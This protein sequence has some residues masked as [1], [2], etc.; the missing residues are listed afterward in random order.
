MDP[1]T[2]TSIAEAVSVVRHAATL[3][4]FRDLGRTAEQARDRPPCRGLANEVL[5]FGGALFS[6]QLLAAE[7]ESTSTE[8][9][10]VG[11]LVLL[12]RIEALF[13]C[14][15]ENL[16]RLTSRLVSDFK[17]ESKVL[18]SRITHALA[19]S[20]SVTDLVILLAAH[21]AGSTSGSDPQHVKDWVKMLIDPRHNRQPQSFYL[22]KRFIEGR[23]AEFPDYSHAA[24]RWIGY[25]EEHWA[26][27]EPELTQ[28]FTMPP[29]S[30]SFVQWALEYARETLPAR[31]GLGCA[32]PAPTIDLS[33]NLCN[34]SISPLHLAA[35]LG[36]PSLVQVL[37]HSGAG[38]GQPSPLGPPLYCAFVGHRVLVVGDS[39]ESW[40]AILRRG[41][42][43]AH[44]HAAVRRLL[45]FRPDCSW[46]FQWPGTHSVSL[47]GLAFWFACLVNDYAIFE[48][49]VEGGAV[50]DNDFAFLISNIDLDA[51]AMPQ[52]HTLA[53][54]L[55]CAF[56]SLYER[57]EQWPWHRAD[58]VFRAIDDLMTQRELEFGRYLGQGKRLAKVSD[59]RLP[60]LIRG[61]ILE[62][63]VCHLK[64]LSID[65]RF[66]PNLLANEDEEEEGTIAHLAVEGNSI[67]IVDVLIAA[68]SDFAAKDGNNRTPLM[69]VEGVPMLSRL[70]HLGIST[71]EIDVTG[72]NIWHLAAA[73]NDVPLLIWLAA[74]D[75]S[76]E[77][78]LA[79]ITEEGYTPLEEA[80]QYN[81]S[82]RVHKTLSTS[83]VEA[84]PAHPVAALSILD[85][86]AV[87]QQ[88]APF[89]LISSAVEWGSLTL[90]Q[91]LCAAGVDP[92]ALDELGRT[93]LHHLNISATPA[94]VTLVQG[95]CDGL[96]LNTADADEEH[97]AA[98]SVIGTGLTPAETILV[99][100]SL[101]QTPDHSWTPSQHNSCRGTLSREAYMLLLTPQVLHHRDCFGRG[102]WA[103]FCQNV[104]LQLAKRIGTKSIKSL[105]HPYDPSL[106]F[107]RTSLFTAIECLIQQGALD[108]H[109]KET[110]LPA[111]LCLR[112]TENGEMD[113]WPEPLLCFAQHVVERFESPLATKF[114]QSPE[115]TKL[116]VAA[117]R[118]DLKKLTQMLNQKLIVGS[119][120]AA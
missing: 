51:Y 61:A 89:P 54:V 102:M 68:G 40:S 120:D 39:P 115:A 82:L 119:A 43:L 75:R 84:L 57:T 117:H 30:F 37:L 65:P 42:R 28:L 58:S 33:N 29:Q 36:L 27:L 55:T 52:K 103:R 5:L 78:N 91:R 81:R 56:D 45:E 13:Q 92:R 35:A 100:T 80:L 41:Q 7:L 21:N 104:I 110:G 74:N 70:M 108:R 6:L 118:C 18:R 22:E 53:M 1:V 59:Q 96:P 69:R 95:L 98:R 25:A 99:N 106:A 34:G 48:K 101:V 38:S 79:A 64:R 114:Y 97:T 63:E 31:F 47:A 32:D 12:R 88:P 76:K 19:R 50:I 94:L 66:D 109:E 113:T 107:L 9:V 46:R 8:P 17:E 24:T 2:P 49:V 23:Q 77:E 71:T 3:L 93:A 112:I 116:F 44:R 67:D 11:C 73:T 20:R 4:C 72:R 83:G 105:R 111:I 15:K 90:V 14:I 60:E 85:A 86:G 16:G 62:D 26:V 10:D 87:C